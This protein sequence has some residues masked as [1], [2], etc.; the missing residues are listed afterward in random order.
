MTARIGLIWAEADGGII[1]RD[2]VMPWHIPEDLAHFKAITSGS[3][4]V[5]GRKTWDS[6]P[7]RFRPLADRRN[8]VVTRQVGW[9]AVGVHVAHSLDEALTLARKDPDTG[10]TWIIGGAEIFAAV[11]DRADRL[12]VT[13]IRA[14]IAGDTFAPEIP[15]HW[16]AVDRDP[17]EGWRTSRTGTAYRFVRYERTT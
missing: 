11:M 7:E 16:R 1:G 6:L 17:V 3:A 10:W 4:V 9:T 15:E 14:E 5:M 13:E 8:V 2:G 12:E